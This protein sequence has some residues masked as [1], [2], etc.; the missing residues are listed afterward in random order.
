MELETTRG[1]LKTKSDFAE[2]SVARCIEPGA[3]IRQAV[4][5]F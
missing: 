2:I 5:D 3:L 1:E 4:K